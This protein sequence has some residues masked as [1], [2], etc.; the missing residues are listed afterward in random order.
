MSQHDAGQAV[1]KPLLFPHAN[2][3]K[4]ALFGGYDF[5]R[6]V[7]QFLVSRNTHVECNRNL[8]TA[9]RSTSTSAKREPAR[10]RLSIAILAFEPGD[11]LARGYTTSW[12]SETTSP[13]PRWNQLS[14]VRRGM[15]SF[16]K[17]A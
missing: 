10:R 17:R 3:R 9:D 16:R 12:S 6:A 1:G 13:T 5:G 7:V 11:A 8:R 15:S 14:A 4:Q 2:L